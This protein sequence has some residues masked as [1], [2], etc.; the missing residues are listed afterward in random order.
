MRVNGMLS[1]FKSVVF[2]QKGDDDPRLGLTERRA[3]AGSWSASKWDVG[4]G[5]CLTTLGKAFGLKIFCV[6][7]NGFIVVGE[8]DRIKQALTG[9]DSAFGEFEVFGDVPVANVNGWIKPQRFFD[10][11][12]EQGGF[13]M[14]IYIRCELF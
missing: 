9:R 14:E 5:R 13:R 7:P 2:K 10:D 3:N 11:L 8:V 12:V 6:L 1:E 4:E